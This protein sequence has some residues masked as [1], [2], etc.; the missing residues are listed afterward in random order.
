MDYNGQQVANLLHFYNDPEMT[1]H[2]EV[3]YRIIK[4]MEAAKVKWALTCSASFFFKGL[5]DEF[6]DFDFIVEEG[7]FEKFVEVFKE[8]GGELNF[9]QNGKEKFFAPEDKYAW[10]HLEG[11]EV[12]IDCP[13]SV[14]TYN[15][16]YSYELLPEHIEYVREIPVIPMEANM[17]LYGMMIAWQ[18]KRRL[19]Y[20]LAKEYLAVNGVLYPELLEF[21]NMPRF[22]RKDVEKIL[23]PC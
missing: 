9:N 2:K 20:E 5:V 18:P 16:K 1:H 4:A 13:F 21:P 11:V 17:M 23:R 19:K 7:S 10:G 8:L 6:H 14:T 3:L 15:T 12:D 22:I